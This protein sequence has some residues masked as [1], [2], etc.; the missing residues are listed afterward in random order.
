MNETGRL[1]IPSP[2][3]EDWNQMQPNGCGRFCSTCQKTVVDFTGYSDEEFKTYFQKATVIPCGR[4]TPQQLSLSIPPKAK[5][6]PAW[7][8][9]N[10]YAAA[11]LLGLTGLTIR[12][13]SQSAQ[14]EQGPMAKA[15]PDGQTA[16]MSL[17]IRGQVIDDS[18]EAIPGAMVTLDSTNAIT[19]VDGNFLL[20]LAAEQQWPMYL[21]IQY[22]LGDTVARV[23]ES[24]IRSNS[25]LKFRMPERNNELMGDIVIIQRKRSFWHRLTKPFRKR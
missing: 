19:D 23:N 18:G 25:I 16:G 9:L 5:R 3:T 15:R 21:K 1:S 7:L 8:R 2:C 24:D 12:A 10:Q 13:Y 6:L 14:I 17:H 20:P 4:F 11:M 22:F